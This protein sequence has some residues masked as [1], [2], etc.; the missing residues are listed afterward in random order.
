MRLYFIGTARPPHPVARAATCADVVGELLD[1]AQ[2]DPDCEGQDRLPTFGV[3]LHGSDRQFELRPE[4]YV[5]VNE[6]HVD[7]VTGEQG[8][9]RVVAG[10]RGGRVGW[11]CAR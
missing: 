6:E 9:V 2:V 10:W 7:R 11:A 8:K 5:L 3:I 1:Y 4:D